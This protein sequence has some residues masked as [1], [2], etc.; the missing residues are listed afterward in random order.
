ME[1]RTHQ[2]SSRFMSPPLRQRVETPPYWQPTSMWPYLD[3]PGLG[4]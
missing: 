1:R 3:Q 2:N 4:S